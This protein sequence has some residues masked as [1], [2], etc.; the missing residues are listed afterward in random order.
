MVSWGIG[1]SCIIRMECAVFVLYWYIGVGCV[2]FYDIDY[3]WRG[4]LRLQ[5]Q[6]TKY[7]QARLNVESFPFHILGVDWTS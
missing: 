5:A 2:G 3:R 4:D 7:R 1:L 6:R